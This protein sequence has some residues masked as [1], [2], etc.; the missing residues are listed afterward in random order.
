[1]NE[2]RNTSF[3][4]T[5]EP[6]SDDKENIPP[7]S[8]LIRRKLN[9][10]RPKPWDS[11]RNKT[12]DYTWTL[13]APSPSHLSCLSKNA[14]SLLNSCDTNDRVMIGRFQPL[15]L[16]QTPSLLEIVSIERPT[17]DVYKNLCIIRYNVETFGNRR[18]VRSMVRNEDYNKLAPTQPDVPKLVV[19]MGFDSDKHPIFH[20]I[21][22]PSNISL[23]EAKQLSRLIK[24]KK[25]L[26][27]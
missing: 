24:K 20:P 26:L 27:S 9:T 10:I 18:Q 15:H 23:E 6:Y 5:F 16:N 3:L 7:D 14:A 4:S 11:D 1:M 21:N 8:H 12:I 13:K 17:E 19:F 22:F 25:H 2:D